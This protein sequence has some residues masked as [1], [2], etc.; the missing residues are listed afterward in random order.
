MGCWE[1]KR[2][3]LIGKN[4]WIPY[5][6]TQGAIY[7]FSTNS[8]RLLFSLYRGIYMD[9]LMIGILVRAHSILCARGLLSELLGPAH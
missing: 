6:I 1:N 3:V 2:N 5:Y 9:T 4:F 7:S 8:Y